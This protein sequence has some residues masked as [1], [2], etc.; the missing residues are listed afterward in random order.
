MA[1]FPKKKTHHTIQIKSLLFPENKLETWLLC[2]GIQPLVLMNQDQIVPFLPKKWV[3]F[4]NWTQAVHFW[5]F[6][7]L[8]ELKY[9]DEPAFIQ[10]KGSE[11]ERG[12]E[13]LQAGIS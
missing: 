5:L 12:G 4:F 9:R 11:K 1:V 13:N 3:E 10:I 2:N 6:R 7:L 8:T